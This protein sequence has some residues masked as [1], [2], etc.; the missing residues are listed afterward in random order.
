[1]KWMDSTWTLS[2]EWVS[3]GN[4]FYK[5]HWCEP[6]CPTSIFLNLPDQ[7]NHRVTPTLGELYYQSLSI[8]VKKNEQWSWIDPK[9]KQV[10][11]IHS[12]SLSLSLG[13]SESSPVMFF[14]FG[15]ESGFVL[16][17]EQLKNKHT[18][19][20]KLEAKYRA[21]ELMRPFQF[22]WVSREFRAEDWTQRLAGSAACHSLAEPVEH[23]AL[24]GSLK[25]TRQVDSTKGVLAR[26]DVISQ[27]SAR[28]RYFT[29]ILLVLTIHV[30]VL[31]LSFMIWIQFR[32]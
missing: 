12:F 24:T 9:R 29:S 18:I 23:G 32:K 20:V 3:R 10:N 21:H 14:S 13:Q 1:M 25:S 27:G 31:I 22:A 26:I 28:L 17:I 4:C 5:S 6:N 8:R 11:W 15:L 30:E 7:L 2:N 19:N 16:Q